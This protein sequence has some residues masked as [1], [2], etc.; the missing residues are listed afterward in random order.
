[1]LFGRR[2]A[3]YRFRAVACG[4]YNMSHAAR[5]TLVCGGGRSLKLSALEPFGEAEIERNGLEGWSEGGQGEGT[6]SWFVRAML[7]V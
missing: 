4:L 7:N 2:C 6:D 5:S 3:S 1:M